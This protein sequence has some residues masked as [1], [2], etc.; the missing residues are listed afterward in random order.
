MRPTRLGSALA[1]LVLLSACTG[2]TV[3]A[4]PTPTPS[5]TQQSAAPVASSTAIPWVAAGQ[6]LALPTAGKMLGTWQPAMTIGYGS[7]ASQLGRT[8]ADGQASAPA[9][10]GTWWFLDSGKQRLAHFSGAGTFLGAVPIPRGALPAQFLHVFQ[11]GAI[12]APFGSSAAD[13]VVSDGR[14]A[15]RVGLPGSEGRAWT[16]D[17]GRRAYARRAATGPVA[18]IEVVDGQ[19]V[20]GRTDWYMTPQGERFSVSIT[21]V[22]LLVELPD[23]VPPTRMAFPLSSAEHPKAHVFAAVE[24]VADAEGTLHL[25]V[26]GSTDEGRK[27]LV[28]SAYLA[29]DRKGFVTTIDRMASMQGGDSP[30]HLHLQPGTTMPSLVLAGDDALRVYVQRSR[31]YDCDSLQPGDVMDLDDVGRCDPDSLSPQ[32]MTCNAGEYVRLDRPGALHDLEGIF[33]LTPRWRSAT[34]IDPWYGRTLWAFRH[35]QEQN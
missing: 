33:G 9:A 12:L 23:L 21:D 30:S 24:Y 26:H 19:P 32:R 3:S 5:W 17:D 15:H 29:I 34:P 22:R 14:V 18:T 4:H 27:S 13:T 10:D 11:N 25:L 2:G 35:C 7:R 16:Y 31:F 6:A 8:G 1:L 28:L 20:V